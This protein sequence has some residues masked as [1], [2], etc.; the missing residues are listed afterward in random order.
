LTASDHQKTGVNGSGRTDKIGQICQSPKQ[1]GK[2]EGG[3]GFARIP[4]AFAC[5]SLK[6][7][8][9]ILNFST[10]NRYMQN[11]EFMDKQS[12]LPR[13]CNWT[14]N[15]LFWCCL[16]VLAFL[17]IQ[18]LFVSS[19]RIPTGSMEPTLTEG[20][21][22]LVNKAILGARL[23]NIFASLRGEETSIYRLPGI[24]A[25]HRNDVLVFNYP[26]A[27]SVDTV[28]MD[29]MV[30]YIKRCVGLPGD[31][32]LIRDG[33][34]R[35]LAL[36]QALSDQ[37]GEEQ[38]K[39]R[40][41]SSADRMEVETLYPN[42]SLFNWDTHSF[43]PLYIPTKGDSLPLTREHVVLYRKLIAWEQRQPVR[44][45]TDGV[46]YIGNKQAT[47]YRFTHDYYFM[48]GDYVQD[49]F[50]SRYW[51][52]VPDDYIAGK[53]WLIWKSVDPSTRKFRGKRFLKQIR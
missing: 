49:S 36:E 1:S 33:Y 24:R 34:Y 21:Y 35:A 41:A 50:D 20:D 7:Q 43:G 16:S 13:I 30:Y 5:F 29:I 45:E 2:K 26:Y 25:I 23:F 38:A 31:S 19:F 4:L 17:F 42:D 3:V 51:G 47:G 52:L 48:A 11:Q 22:V 44:M 6:K 37:T 9:K 53:A 39:Q 15:L 27:H 8:R 14:V 10:G 32:V 40:H 28:R 12:F 46:V 18:I